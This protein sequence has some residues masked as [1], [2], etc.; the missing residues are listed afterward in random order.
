M[1]A[2]EEK[3]AEVHAKYGRT[4]HEILAKEKQYDRY[5]I[6]GAIEMLVYSK[7]LKNLTTSKSERMVFGFAWLV[8]EVQNG[9]FNQYFCNSAGDYWKDVLYG[10]EA[11]SDKEG[12]AAFKRVLSIFPNSTPSPEM[13]E[14][15]DQL[16]KLEGLVEVTKEE[17]LEAVKKARQITPDS[18]SGEEGLKSFT[19]IDLDLDKRT[20]DSQYERV[21]EHWETTSKSYY[22]K[23]YP[24]SKLVYQFVKNHAEDFDLEKA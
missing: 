15:H 19:F 22:S 14:R 8:R 17:L 23:P 18:N 21:Q 1:S 11:I 20:E 2:I 16:S 4:I 7:I 6:L 24:D 10:L 13:S 9:G 3:V 5:E 12:L